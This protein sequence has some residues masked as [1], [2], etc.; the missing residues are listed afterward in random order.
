MVDAIA[1]GAYGLVGTAPSPATSGTSLVLAG[2]YGSF[3]AAPFDLLLWP[4]SAMPIFATA[5]TV[6]ANAEIARCTA[7]TTTTNAND[8][9]AIT[10]AQYGTS[11]RSVIIGDQCC[12]PIDA[13]LLTQIG[14]TVQT[15][16]FNLY[17]GEFMMVPQAIA[18]ATGGGSAL[19]Q[20]TAYAQPFSITKTV[21]LTSIATN[22]ATAGGTGS[23]CRFGIYADSSGY[24]GALLLDAGTVP[25]V[26]GSQTITGPSGLS[27]V[28]TPGVYWVV[29]APQVGTGPVVIMYSG[30]FG[31]RF[32]SGTSKVYSVG[33]WTIT[34][35]TAGLP[36]PF[37]AGG[38]GIVI[39]G[40]VFPGLILGA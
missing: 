31:A 23:V 15:L 1:N 26:T 8:T 33:G 5:G 21:T 37:T 14:T 40:S 16:P 32:V 25:T 19:T 12:Q 10:R 27:L 7:V 17:T 28:L 2:G 20:G 11:A 35:V 4:A 30:V 29:I 36:N 38:T 3:P 34:S 9:L 13:N 24:P 22:V 18:S 39:N 6:T